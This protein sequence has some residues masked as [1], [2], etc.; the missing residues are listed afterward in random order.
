MGSYT[1][2]SP[3]HVQARLPFLDDEWEMILLVPEIPVCICSTILLNTNHDCIIWSMLCHLYNI[4]FLY[5]R[6]YNAAAVYTA[7][8]RPGVYT[9]RSIRRASVYDPLWKIDRKY[10]GCTLIFLL[11]KVYFEYALVFILRLLRAARGFNN[12]RFYTG[13]LTGVEKYLLRAKLTL[14]IFNMT[15]LIDV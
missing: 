12:I 9:A 5:V 7:C 1:R 14:E 11:N 4:P 2:L 3:T 6:G 8:I 10:F 15:H 13:C